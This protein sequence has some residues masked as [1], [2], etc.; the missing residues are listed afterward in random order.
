MQHRHVILNN[1]K[2][3]NPSFRRTRGRENIQETAA[4]EAPKVI[5]ENQKRKLRRLFRLFEESQNTRNTNR[6]VVFDNKIEFIEVKFYGIFNR[7]L[8]SKFLNKYGLRPV[9]YIDFNRTIIFEVYEEELFEVFKKDLNSA[10]NSKFGESYS[11]KSYN[12]IA[13][14]YSFSYVDSRER[15]KTIKTDGILLE[16]ED[17][18]SEGSQIQVSELKKYLDSLGINYSVGGDFINVNSLKQRDIRFIADNFDVVIAITSSRVPIAR[19]GALGPKTEYGFSAFIP[20]NIPT[21]GL[22][23]TGISRI[24]PF[25]NLIIGDKDHTNTSAYWDEEGH[26]TSVAGVI[27]FGDDFYANTSNSY[28]AKAKI[29][30]IKAIHFRNDP[31]DIKKLLDDILDLKH[32]H[33]IKLFN[34]SLNL[35]SYKK[36][37]ETISEFAYELDKLAHKH[38][39]LIFISSGNFD[40][41][42]LE[43]ILANEHDNHN[44]GNFHYSPSSESEIHTCEDT[45][46]QIP[47]ESYNNVTIGALAGNRDLRNDNSDITPVNIYPSYYTRKFHYDF[48]QNINGYTLKIENKHLN[49]PDMVYDGGDYFKESSYLEVLTDQNSGF[50]RKTSGSSFSAPFVTSYAAELLTLYPNLKAQTIKALLINSA[51]YYPKKQ[52]PHFS[53]RRDNLLQKMIG[54]G[55]PDK[56][57]FLGNNAST[58]TFI[59]EDHIKVGEILKRPIYLPEYLINSGSKLQ[60]DISLS[61]SFD[62]IK[63]NQLDYC[64]FHMAFNVVQNIEIGEISTR[65]AK[66]NKDTPANTP[67]YGIKSFQW[68]ED[69]YGIESRLFSNCQKMQYRLQPDDYTGINLQLAIAVRCLVKEKYLDI[70]RDED[71]HF[72]LVIRI[73][74]LTTAH[75]TSNLYN[76][77]L[78]IN[79]YLNLESSIEIED[80]L[81]AEV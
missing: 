30:I 71:L 19:V 22:I 35:E 1:N 53:N 33:G 57:V 20:E 44:Y 59:I 10:I 5:G 80:S 34:L 2:D 11:G 73:T 15:I 31:L 24:E 55:I 39:L 29:H 77:M 25:E 38:D 78:R 74:E 36:Y 67:I 75:K 40:F 27:I 61:F 7:D 26:G 28:N 45:N 64:P 16:I 21:V 14:I 17:T 58:V 66:P 54:F 81:D 9:R 41:N 65:I 63:G 52:L 6:N 60:F 47:G 48:S 50:Y 72:S 18:Q 23:D 68:S 12:L 62:P 46:L 3:I 13:T 32:N 37:N 70:Y 4:V 79:N 76:E 51:Y 56:E 8:H 43:E 42:N 69:H 49:K